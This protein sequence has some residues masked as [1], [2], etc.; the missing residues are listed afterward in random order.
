MD[1]CALR[2]NACI[3][4]LHGQMWNARS[5]ADQHGQLLTTTHREKGQSA[6]LPAGQTSCAALH[7]LR[8]RGGFDTTGSSSRA[9]APATWQHPSLQ[10]D[11]LW[12]NRIARCLRMRTCDMCR[13]TNGL[14][15]SLMTQPRTLHM[16][17]REVA[18]LTHMVSLLSLKPCL[19][20]PVSE[21]MYTVEAVARTTPPP[22][23][24]PS[25]T[26]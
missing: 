22:P 4:V 16:H 3:A 18:G 5:T 11:L 20:V 17:R 9:E 10:G 19:F 6:V 26:F 2:G 23:P 8:G 24:P 14:F 12:I 13:Q 1:S 15:T 25:V 21:F 7:S